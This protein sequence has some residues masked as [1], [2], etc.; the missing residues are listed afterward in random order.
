MDQV[1][2]SGTAASAREALRGALARQE[3]LLAVLLRGFERTLAAHPPP[4][5]HEAWHGGAERFYAETAEE[6]R[7]DLGLVAEHLAAALADTRRALTT[8]NAVAPGG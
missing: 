2:I 7:R 1:E 4:D 5:L 3:E 8:L 6:L